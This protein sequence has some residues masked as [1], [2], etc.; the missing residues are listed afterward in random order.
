MGGERIDGLEVRVGTL[1]G[2]MTDVQITLAKLEGDMKLNNVMTAN[3][4]TTLSDMK[5]DT[6]SMVSLTKGLTI[7]GKIIMWGGGLTA[8]IL[9]VAAVI[10]MGGPGV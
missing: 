7:I 3:I 4:Q 5:T 9:G 1:E 8:L 10:K 6:G 2:R